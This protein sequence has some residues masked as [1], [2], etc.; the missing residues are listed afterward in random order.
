[1]VAATLVSCAICPPKDEAMYT[2][3]SELTKL[4]KA[5]EATV[6]YEEV[7]D[8][9]DDRALLI[10][11]TD[12]DPSLLSPFIDYTLKIMRENRHA[13]LLLCTPDGE[14]S[15]LEDACCN[16]SLDAHRWMERPRQPCSFTLNL[17]DLC[18]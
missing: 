18:K 8:S 1:L 16:P 4:C 11:A 17:N 2:L 15:L 9:I 13:S 12:H 10:L 6:R 14:T 3:A 7:P 5:V